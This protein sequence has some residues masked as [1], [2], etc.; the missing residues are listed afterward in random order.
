M[1]DLEIRWSPAHQFGH[2]TIAGTRLR[3]EDLAGRVWAGELVA[4]VAADYDL[5]V[6]HVRLACWFIARWPYPAD[7]GRRPRWQVAASRAWA[8][9]AEEWLTESF[10]R[11]GAGNPT[12]PGIDL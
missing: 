3:P 8:S 5:D 4:D 9:W 1:N 11:K 7:V 2:P 12:D 6:Q 10:W